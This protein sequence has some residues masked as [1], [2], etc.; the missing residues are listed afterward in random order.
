MKKC[1]F[2]QD[3]VLYLKYLVSS[4]GISIEFQKIKVVKERPELKSVQDIKVFLGF[5]KFYWQFI[6]GLNRIAAP[7][8]SMLNMPASLERSMSYKLEFDDDGG[9]DSINGHGVSDNGI[10]L[11]KNLGK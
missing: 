8:T 2:H 1:Y 6:Q 10:E 4:K 3:E 7:L 11:A 5:A 9:S